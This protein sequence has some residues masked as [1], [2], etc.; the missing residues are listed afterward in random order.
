M[1]AAH[2][3]IE[4]ELSGPAALLRGTA[5][6]LE[7]VVNGRASAEAIAVALTTRLEEAPAFFRGNDVKICVEDGPLAPGCL[8]RL[9]ELATKFALRI[10]EV[11]ATAVPKPNLAAG[12]APTESEFG[13]EERTNTAI[14]VIGADAQPTELSASN[15]IPES[16]TD[17][18]TFTALAA[19]ANA[20]RDPGFGF[21]EPTQ[22]A[23]PL[24][25]AATPET[26][27][28]TAS[29]GTRLVVGPVRS[30]VI[31]DHTGHVVVFGDVNPGAEVR[32]TGNIMVLGRLRGTAHAA[33]G[34]D[35]GFILA[36]RLEPQQ[37]RIGRM[38]AR[39]AD[40]DTPATQTEIAYAN[41]DGIVVEQYLGKLPRNLATSL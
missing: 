24:A 35:V 15:L 7:L 28:N 18:E 5:R 4:P 14:A 40:S 25:L 2:A 1:D 31:L 33:I 32:A 8:A 30:G 27:L 22:T 12:S 26:E 10:T 20:E 41:G 39:A 16:T 19:L 29:G 36:L 17:M 3:I 34:Q 11:V 23:V 6:G 37:L 13:D 21:E 9:D 38:V